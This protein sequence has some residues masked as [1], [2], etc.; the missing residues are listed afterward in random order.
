MPKVKVYNM[1]AV[2]TGTLTLSDEVFGKEY[3]E[4]LIHEVVVAILANRRQGTKSTLT[5][6]EVR[7]HAK[8]PWKQK[9]TGRARQGSSKGPQWKG[10]GIVFTPKPRDFSKKVN[11]TARRVAFM[12]AI[13][14]KLAAGEITVVNEVKFDEMKTKLMQV[15]LDAFNFNKKTL[16]VLNEKD[17]TVLK[18]A[19]NIPNLEVTTQDLLNTYDLVAN[20]FVVITEAA[21]KSIEEAYL[22]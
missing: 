21:I 7:G 2:E 13:S 4:G 19:S 18:V 22:V 10:G 15:L 14:A 11:K 20:K 1:K 6:S 16:I 12:S 8:K 17:E 9:G 3:N 5:R